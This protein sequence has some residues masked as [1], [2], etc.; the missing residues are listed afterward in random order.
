[1]NLIN[2]DVPFFKHYSDLS[3]RPEIKLIRAKHGIGGYGVYLML[4]ERLSMTQ[5]KEEQVDFAILAFDFRCS[6]EL[7][8]SVLCDFGLFKINVNENVI[9]YSSKYLDEQTKK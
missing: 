7:V 6:E 4:L 8:R 2:R 5:N 1:M 3:K 9:T